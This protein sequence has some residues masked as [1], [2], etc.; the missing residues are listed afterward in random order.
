MM[1]SNVYALRCGTSA[2]VL[3]GAAAVS[4]SGPAMADVIISTKA[5]ENMSCSDGVCTPTAKVAY[6]NVTDLQNLLAG[7]SVEITTGSGALAARTRNIAINAGLS[8]ASAYVLTLDAYDSVIVDRAVADDGS[9]GLTIVTNDGGSGGALSFGDS[10]AISFL[11]T[12][13]IL[14]INGAVYTLAN[15]IGMLASDIA[16]NPSGNYALS[17]D[18]NARPDGIYKT[19]PIPTTFTGNFEG[20]GHTISHLSINDTVDLN[21]GLFA[22]TQG[23]GQLRDIGLVDA[24]VR[25]AATGGGSCGPTCFAEVGILVGDNVSDTIVASYATGA[26][27]GGGLAAVGGLVG[28]NGGAISNSYATCTVTGNHHSVTGG[29]AGISKGSITGSYATGAT[30][31]AAQGAAGGL[32]G[33]SFAPITDSYATGSVTGDSQTTL[34]GLLAGNSAGIVD[35]YSTGAVTGG[36]DS[37]VGGFIGQYEEGEITDSYWD[38]TTSGQSLGAA[39]RTPAGVTGLTTVQLQSGLPAGFSSAIWGESGSINNGFPYLLALPPS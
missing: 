29:L 37:Y 5:T 33:S 10:G 38:T 15:G 9:G 28:F 26:V 31:V 17:V 12:S 14:T 11:G 36:S 4:L 39:G 30:A 3:L 22:E 16:D 24:N 25:G 8:W 1:F 13:N 32:V 20:L 23:G 34:G 18:Y 2:A 21:V 35:S 7:S 6:L 27:K 19:P